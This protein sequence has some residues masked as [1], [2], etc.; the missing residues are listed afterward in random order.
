MFLCVIWVVMWLSW[1]LLILRVWLC[2]V[3][4]LGRKLVLL[5]LLVVLLLFVLLF[6]LLVSVFRCCC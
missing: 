5:L 1:C 2:S 4:W 3:I 6:L